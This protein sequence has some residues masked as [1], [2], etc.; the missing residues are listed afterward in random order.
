MKRLHA[1]RGRCSSLKRVIRL[2]RS[3]E[4]GLRHPLLGPLLLLLLVVLL[5][6]M[7]LHETSESIGSEI[8]QLCI[9]IALVLLTAVLTG[10]V[11]RFVKILGALLTARAPPCRPKTR[12]TPVS[13]RPD[14][15]PL[16]L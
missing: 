6:L 12:P 1:S 15:V 7:V 8:G 11:R 10:P 5:A 2:R 9:G 3:L 4:R 13:A 16:R 14:T